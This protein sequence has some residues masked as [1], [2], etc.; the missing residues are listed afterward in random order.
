MPRAHL[1]V[2]EAASR[3]GVNPS[4]VRALVAAGR[5]EATKIG[6]RWLVDAASVARRKERPPRRG[7]A[8][9]SAKAWGVLLVAVGRRPAWLGVEDLSRV[10]R[11]LREQ[12]LLALWPRLGARA[13]VQRLRAHPS[14]LERI[15][16]EAGAV[17]AG[18]SAA[19]EHHL[20]LVGAGQLEVYF[21]EQRLARLVKRYA[22]EPDDHPNLL[23]KAVAEPWPFDPQETVA[24]ASVVGVDL[25]E[26]DDP[27]SRRA[28]EE[29]L[30]RA[31]ASWST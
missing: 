14:D 23:L 30:R 11:A 15:A 2:A 8:F 25:V 6:G 4:R 31:Q 22:L 9:T 12:G 19:V 27:R 13:A 10:R 1:S 17:L 29:L 3:L 16:A 21:P 7:R 24:P 28:G 20:D 18:A 5:L 26:S